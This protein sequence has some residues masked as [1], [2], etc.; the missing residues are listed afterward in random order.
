MVAV[1]GLQ[2][3]RSRPVLEDSL[4]WRGMWLLHCWEDIDYRVVAQGWWVC[5]APTE[6]RDNRRSER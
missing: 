4:P 2:H 1:V 6:E 5:A 3:P